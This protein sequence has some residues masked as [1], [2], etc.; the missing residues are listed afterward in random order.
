[1]RIAEVKEWE[2]CYCV[3]LRKLQRLRP[4]RIAAHTWGGLRVLETLEASCFM[5]KWA[6]KL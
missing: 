3:D 4:T 1:M 6:L 2:Q 5:R